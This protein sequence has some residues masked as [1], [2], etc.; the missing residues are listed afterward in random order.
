MLRITSFFRGYGVENHLR[1]TECGGI[2]QRCPSQI[3][4]ANVRLCKLGNGTGV[5]GVTHF[6]KVFQRTGSDGKYT[7]L[8]YGQETIRVLPDLVQ[9]LPV[10]ASNCF[11]V[12]DC[13]RLVSD[14]K[15]AT[16][17]SVTWHGKRSE[18]FYSLKFDGKPK[19]R[20]YW[21]IDLRTKEAE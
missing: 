15:S 11:S 5:Q 13:V 18:P 16:V 8:N 14:G 17:A 9:E 1:H 20:R 19:S 21:N 12:G 7:L 6:S 3:F 4:C 10:N 2:N